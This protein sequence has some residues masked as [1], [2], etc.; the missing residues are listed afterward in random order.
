MLKGLL[1]CLKGL[2]KCLK[3]LLKGL[4]KCLKGLLKGLLKCLFKKWEGLHKDLKTNKER[5]G[6][7]RIFISFRN[8]DSK[9]PSMTRYQ[10]PIYSG[11]LIKM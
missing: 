7:V 1:K 4:L 5:Y 10:C 8:W 9:G 2:L 6:S 3:G 11:T